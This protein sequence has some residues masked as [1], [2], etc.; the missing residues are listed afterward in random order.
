[1]STPELLYKMYKML[2]RISY[3]YSKNISIDRAIVESEL[4]EILEE[5][6]QQLGI[7]R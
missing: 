3:L 7:I 1:M 6:Y 5:C 2:V 4:R